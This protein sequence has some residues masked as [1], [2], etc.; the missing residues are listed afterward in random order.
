MPVAW[1]QMA[2]PGPPPGFA[3]THAEMNAAAPLARF[4]RRT[5]ALLDCA[6]GNGDRLALVDKAIPH[7]K[8]DLM[9]SETS[10][11]DK[12][13]PCDVAPL[14]GHALWRTG[15]ELVRFVSAPD[16]MTRFGLQ[17][18]LL[19]LALN[20]DPNTRDRESVQAAKQF[21]LHLLYWTAAE[22]APLA[23]ARSGPRAAEHDVRTRRQLL[24]PLTFAG[25][26][27]VAALLKDVDLSMAGAELLDCDDAAV[28]AGTRPT[29]AVIRLPGWH[30]LGDAAFED[31][32]RRLHRRLDAAAGLLREV[33]TGSAA[34][35]APWQRLPLRARADTMAAIAGL[36]LPAPV[37]DALGR[38]A[39]ALRDLPAPVLARL[40]AGPAEPRKHLMTLN[41]PSYS[42]NLHA[43]IRNTAATPVAA[44]R[45][46]LLSI[47]P[48]L[49]SG[50]GGAGLLWLDGVPSVRIRRGVGAFSQAEWRAR[51][52]WQRAFALHNAA[53]LAALLGPGCEQV[54]RF[55]DCD[56]GWV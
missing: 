29:G 5:I 44:A 40:R 45:E 23:A 26:R 49:F 47:Q 54:R 15:L 27:L 51:T 33:F 8:Y 43:P 1:Q 16:V 48:K 30:V 12:P 28:A 36:D 22:L 20:C 39:A 25:A 3:L 11:E 50:T 56:R 10:A 17:G 37:Q 21:H 19:H 13:G 4:H 55:A 2:V 52:D 24:D 53:A 6:G 41:A 32:I 38:L 34:V 9:L 18:G 31:L 14:T 7:A 35:P 42:L 46:V